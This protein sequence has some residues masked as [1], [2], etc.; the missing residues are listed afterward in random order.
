MEPL[1]CT[2]IS[3]VD[4]DY[5]SPDTV[6]KKRQIK[7]SNHQTGISQ[8]VTRPNGIFHMIQRLEAYPFLLFGSIIEGNAVIKLERLVLSRVLIAKNLFHWRTFLV[9]FWGWRLLFFDYSTMRIWFLTISNNF[10]YRHVVQGGSPT[11]YRPDLSKKLSGCHHF[12]IQRWQSNPVQ[13]M[14]IDTYGVTFDD[15]S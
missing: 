4:D 1:F 13:E 11:F 6:S 2:G 5:V 7:H 14:D 9:L 3:L 15:N 8:H 12:L 10:Y